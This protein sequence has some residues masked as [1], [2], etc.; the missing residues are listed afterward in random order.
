M[1]MST[2]IYPTV[3][4]GAIYKSVKYPIS[5]KLFSRKTN[6]FF[7]NPIAD[8][9]FNAGSV[10]LQPKICIIFVMLKT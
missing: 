9:F 1:P 7:S 3:L 6:N 10:R 4:Q 2:V 8:H 5:G